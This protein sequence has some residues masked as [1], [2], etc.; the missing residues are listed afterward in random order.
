[1]SLKAFQQD[2][3]FWKDIFTECRLLFGVGRGAFRVE[4]ELLGVPMKETRER[5]DE[6]LD[7]LH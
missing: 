3:V 7:V 5:F 4:M 1:M 6:S 2:Y